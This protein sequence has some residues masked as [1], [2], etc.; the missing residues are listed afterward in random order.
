MKTDDRHAHQYKPNIEDDS[1]CV[2]TLVTAHPIVK[3]TIKRTYESKQHE[4]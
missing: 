1:W 3:P 4:T 2:E